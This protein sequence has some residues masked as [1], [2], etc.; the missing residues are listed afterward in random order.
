MPFVLSY[1][2]AV[3]LA[4]GST[5]P[6]PTSTSPRPSDA[7]GVEHHRRMQR[8]SFGADLLKDRDQRPVDAM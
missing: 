5:R 7:A 3:S 6:S 8:E 2:R 1:P 4:A